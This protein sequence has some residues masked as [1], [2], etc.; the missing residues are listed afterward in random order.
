MNS[1]N[2]KGKM[3]N[4]KGKRKVLF[5]DFHFCLLPLAF[6][7][8]PCVVRADQRTQPPTV[9]DVAPTGVVRGKTATIQ[10]EGSRL[11]GSSAILFSDPAVTG[12]IVG[13]KEIPQEPERRTGQNSS[14]DLGDRPPKNQVT[15]EVSA[16]ASAMPGVVRFRL[17]TPLG[18]SNTGVLAVSPF[19]EFAAPTPPAPATP[20]G[21]QAAPLNPATQLVKMPVTVVGAVTRP[22]ESSVI[23]FDTKF[24]EQYVFQVVAGAIGS[25]LEPEMILRDGAGT[26]ILDVH[27]SVMITPFV[28]GGRLSLEVRDYQHRGGPRYFY[29]LNAGVVPY[30]SGAFPLGF[31]RGKP[32]QVALFGANLLDHDR[33]SPSADA[34]ISAVPGA[35]NQIRLA[36]GDLPEV[37]E[38]EGVPRN[39]T[40]QTAQKVPVPVTINGVIAGGMT[41]RGAVDRDYYRF[42]AKKDQRLLLEVNAQRLG[43]PLDSMIEVLDAQGRPIERAVLRA[44]AET[45]VALADAESTRG[46]I[47][48]L[49]FAGIHVNDYL[50]VANELLRVA[51]LPRGPDEDIFLHTAAGRRIGYLDTTPTSLAVN[52]PVYKVE[53][54]PPGA[55]F[56]SNGLP[57][58]HLYYR[59]D[60]A[61]GMSPTRD[62]V[63]HFTAPA[64]GDYMVRV[65]DARGI[66]NDRFAYRLSIRDEHPD[67]SMTASPANPNVPRGGR[68]A[69]QVTAMRLEGFNGAID[70]HV[71]GLPTGVHA[72]AAVIPP[73]QE[74][75]V[76]EIAADTDAQ[77]ADPTAIRIVGSG[78]DRSHEAEA[79]DRLRLLSLAPPP[80]V[81]VWMEPATVAINPGQTLKIKVNVERAAGFTGRVPV[82][83]RNLP[84]GVFIPDIGLNGVL[85]NEKESS[86]EFTLVAEDWA[87]PIEQPLYAVARVETRSPTASAY[88]SAPLWLNIRPLTAP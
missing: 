39:D 57:V 17:A 83:I 80:D 34:T 54:H 20:G 25:S 72:G 75:T 2:A 52:T 60:D 35:L 30:V 48:I 42:A 21:P 14:I 46:S 88:A 77:L 6:C 33:W 15:V 24:D 65:E 87:A 3:Q 63:V 64:D 59:N 9:A 37:F 10:I 13:V 84:P 47:R 18:T 68:V 81:N 26:T 1:C 50:Y 38:R 71:E 73:G 29:R 79:G 69:V 40:P 70:V 58:T 12:K 41:A 85:V 4:A 5:S 19:D 74:S 51:V 61:Q 82:D 32:P 55:Q 78:G 49:S 67:F 45:S 43:S 31:Q 66:E 7:L 22:G 27:D 62:S 36:V 56:P 16:A 76:V 86:R 28:D 11:E 8:L 53:V 44:V 23:R